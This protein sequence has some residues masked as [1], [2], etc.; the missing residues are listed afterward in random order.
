MPAKARKTTTR[1][2]S[3][4]SSSSTKRSSG[5]RKTTKSAPAARSRREPKQS[6]APSEDGSSHLLP[7]KGG[8]P[9]YI[10]LGA[11]GVFG[12]LDWPLAIGIGAGYALLRRSGLLDDPSRRSEES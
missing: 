11:L 2:A 9:M 10:G 5:P 12:V 6:A 8:L 1:S 7:A 3:S 4:S